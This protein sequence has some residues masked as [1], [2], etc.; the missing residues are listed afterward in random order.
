MAG[1]F[2]HLWMRRCRYFHS[3]GEK[4]NLTLCS[5]LLVC[6][7]STRLHG[8]FYENKQHLALCRIYI[9]DLF[10]QAYMFIMYMYLH[11]FNWQAIISH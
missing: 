1:N 5:K 11:V 4:P 6:Y 7:G 9:R 8:V 3:S 2:T 10:L